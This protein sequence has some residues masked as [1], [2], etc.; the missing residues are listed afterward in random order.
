[1]IKRIFFIAIF[2]TLPIFANSKVIFSDSEGIKSYTLTLTKSG[3]NVSFSIDNKIDDIKLPKNTYPISLLKQEI[4][5]SDY[6][7][8]LLDELLSMFD[9]DINSTLSARDFLQALTEIL[10]KVGACNESNQLSEWC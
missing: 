2:F 1:M 8:A 4:G 5:E 6:S 7:E 3:S 9:E 10:S